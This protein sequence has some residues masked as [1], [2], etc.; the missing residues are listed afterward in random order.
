MRTE[1]A[2]VMMGGNGR[3]CNCNQPIWESGKKPVK[4]KKKSHMSKE[5]EVDFVYIWE[6]VTMRYT[7][8]Y[9]RDRRIRDEM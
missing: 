3:R 8:L 4:E 2:M 6:M 1:R 5:P 7:L 9:R